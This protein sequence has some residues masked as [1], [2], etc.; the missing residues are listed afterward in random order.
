MKE[1]LQP[2][3]APEPIQEKEHQGLHQT[4]KAKLMDHK[5]LKKYLKADQAQNI[6]QLNQPDN[7][8][9]TIEQ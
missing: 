9:M 7:S 5:I 4:F 1:D 3:K 6:P 2:L 8:A